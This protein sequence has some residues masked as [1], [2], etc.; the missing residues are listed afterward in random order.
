MQKHKGLIGQAAL[1]TVAIAQGDGRN[2][3]LPF[4]NK[5]QAVAHAFAHVDGLHVGNAGMPAQAGQQL[6]CGR[7]C[8]IGM[9]AVQRNAQAHHVVL[10]MRMQKDSA[11]V[12]RMN[13]GIVT[14]LMD[15]GDGMVET[16]RLHVCEG[17]VGFR[18]GKMREHTVQMHMRTGGQGVQ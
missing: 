5:A 18:L 6:A 14:P 8:G 10:Q 3:G 15:H 13:D 17:G 2:A 12:G 1:V 4:G 16:P 9:A 11:A 7:K